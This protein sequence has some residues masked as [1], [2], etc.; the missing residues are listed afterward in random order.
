MT[1][2][3]KKQ[4]HCPHAIAPRTFANEVELDDARLYEHP[5]LLHQCIKRLGTKG[6]AEGWDNTKRAVVVAPLSHAQ[7]SRVAGGQ[8]LAPPFGAKRHRRCTNGDIGGSG[9]G[10]SPVRPRDGEERPDLG[11][12][13]RVIFKPDHRVHLGECRGQLPSVPLRHAARHDERRATG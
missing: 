1:C 9:G 4:S 13:A 6:P 8:A 11:G 2:G 10:V 5:N 7:V 12:Q 3:S